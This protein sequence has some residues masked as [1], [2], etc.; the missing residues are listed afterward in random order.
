MQKSSCHVLV[1]ALLAAASLQSARA[2]EPEALFNGKDL[3]GWVGD[4]QLWSVEDGA[5]TGRS[6][7][8]HPVKA[9]TFL[10]W[11]NGTVEDFELRC[12]C[13]LTPSTPGGF[14]NSGIQYRSKVLD[15][16]KWAVGGYQAD[17]EA[18]PNYSGILYEER[19]TRGIMALGGE[20]VVWDAQGQKQVVGRLGSAA[21]IQSAIKQGDWNEYT[22]I[23]QGTHLR[24]FING[25]Q[26]VDVT[27]QT[28]DKAATSGVIALQMHVGAPFTA[29]FKNIRLTRLGPGGP[30]KTLTVASYN[31]KVGS[32]ATTPAQPNAWA[33]RRALLSGL[34]RDISPDVMGTQEGLYGQISD[35]A[36]DLPGYAW[37]GVGRDDGK[38]AGEFMA[39]FYRTARLQ[40]LST[41]HFWLSDTPEIAGSATWGNS[42]KRMVTW[43]KFRDLETRQEFH[44]I[45]T[46]FDHRVQLARERSS[47]LIRQR[48]EALG[49]KLPVIM[50]GDFNAAA[51]NNKSY[52]MLVSDGFFK[53]TWLTAEARK[54]EGYGTFNDFKAL[55]KDGPRIDW[56][57]A[58]G[59]VHADSAEIV[60]Y[61]KDGVFPSDHCPILT[62]LSFPVEAR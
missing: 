61:S 48:I 17:L 62:R 50:T 40:P 21:E 18:G 5:I 37:I 12:Q 1:A 35:L 8:E 52:D 4:P 7:A 54:G 22:I 19:M 2:A 59:R 25:K 29:Q 47:Q 60:T 43:V 10:I 41:N 20:K 28:T 55:E 13:R 24:H 49:D 39:V 14:A 6:T 23:A 11:T 15:A 38:L 51:G 58:H 9:N 16:S 3:S 57:L 33:G 34:V 56:I 46:H 53:D 32:K 30:S 26:T 44:F 31:L 27:D 42:N 36:N 45:N